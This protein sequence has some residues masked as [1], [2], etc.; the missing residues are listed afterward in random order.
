MSIFTADIILFL[1]I[2][3]I[4]NNPLMNIFM[5]IGWSFIF[6][7]AVIGAITLLIVVAVHKLL[8]RKFLK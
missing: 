8:L 5:A 1:L 7:E 6:G 2:F 4:L 3:S